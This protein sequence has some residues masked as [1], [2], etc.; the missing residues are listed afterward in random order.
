MS[1]P[2]SIADI[3]LSWARFRGRWDWRKMPVLRLPVIRDIDPLP[4]EFDPSIKPVD[5]PRVEVWIESGWQDFEPAYRLVGSIPG[6]NL[7]KVLEVRLV[8]ELYPTPK[9]ETN[10]AG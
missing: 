5:V 8:R 6:T 1:R 2:L 9:Q 4:A 3:E 7:E 10:D